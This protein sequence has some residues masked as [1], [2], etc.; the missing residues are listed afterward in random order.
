MLRRMSALASLL[1]LAASCGTP[2][3]DAR[4]GRSYP[5]VAI[6][7]QCWMALNLDHGVVVA[8]ARPRDAS[9]VEKSCYG[10]DPGSCRTFGGLY[11]WNES[12]QA[13]PAGW[14]LP[15]RE[16]W[17]ALAA[18]LGTATAGEKLKARK[19]HVPAFGGTDEVGFTALPA[20]AA[21][22]GRSAD[23]PTGPCSG[24]RRRTAGNGPSRSRS[25]RLWHPEPPRYRRMVFDEAYL[26][27]NAFS[28][29]CV[30]S[31]R[32]TASETGPAGS[33]GTADPS[34]PG[35]TELVGMTGPSRRASGRPSRGPSQT[36]R[37]PR[38]PEQ[39]ER[40]GVRRRNVLC[41]VCEDISPRL[42]SY[43]DP[44][45]LTPV[46]DRLRED[47]R[48]LHPHVLELGGVRAE[49]GRADHRH[50]RDR[51]RREQH[52]HE[53][54]GPRR[55]RAVRGGAAARRA[56]LRRVPARGRLLHD[57][58]REDRLPV[59]PAPHR[60]G[61]ERRARRTGRTGPRECPSSRS[62][63]SRRRT[64]PRCWDRANDPVVVPPE[65]VILPP[66]YPDSPA[67]RR[68]VARVY[69][70][71]AIMDRQVGELLAELERGGRSPTTRSSIFYSDNGGPLPRGQAGA[72]RLRA[73]RAV[74]DP[75]PRRRPTRARWWTTS[76]PSW[77]SRPRSSRWP[78]YRCRGTCRAV[79]SGATRRRPRGTSS[80][81]PATGWTSGSTTC[82]RRATGA[83]STSATTGRTCR[84]IRTSTTAG[85]WRRCRT[86]SAC[87]TRGG[88]IPSSR[89][90]SSPRSRRRSST[91]PRPT[92]TRSATSRATRRTAS[93]RAAAGRPRRLAARDRRPAGAPRD[94]ARRVA[95]AGRRPAEDRGPGDRVARR[96]RHPRVP[97]RGLGD[98]LPGGRPGLAPRPLVPLHGAVRG[99]ERRRGH[100]RRQP[101]RLRAERRGAVRRALATGPS[102]RL[103]GTDRSS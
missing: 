75:L 40:R 80:S 37:S 42:G 55:P 60:L 83:S 74:H 57:E 19:D 45:A 2:L 76:W 9:A 17:E 92:R 96:A 47:R 13:C 79:P 77:T 62:S 25:T 30:K 24:P 102:T 22:R 8:D 34:S 29:R 15:S 5:T 97:D 53:H 99:E 41:I 26:K 35:K 63:T 69:S 67:V 48:A 3:V 56:P 36:D 87:A 71:V 64:S 20:G 90:G 52:A 14:H 7:G 49:P 89:S 72:A 1:L 12:R 6:G 50:V 95:L 86:S 84:A 78:A 73:P 100:R 39:T 94:R 82:G 44:V 88:S 27:E 61:R 103:C 70:N 101:R 10:N 91:T 85:R 51:D 33:A 58:Q 65:R 21:F 66:Y 31:S 43:G 81:P 93:P 28:A 68:D 98:R 38:R 4:D 23:R 59:H 18:H 32:G 16:E 54:E 11:T 46:L